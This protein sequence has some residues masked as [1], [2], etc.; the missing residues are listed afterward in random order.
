MGSVVLGMT[1]SLDGF[2]NDRHGDVGR[3]YSDLDDFM[4][5]EAGQEAIA[6][7]GAV[8][9]GRRAY[10]MGQGDFTGYEFQVPI[11]VVTHRAPETA[12][13]GEND[14]LTFTF[15]TDGVERA[16]TQA[17][18][19]AGDR[20][21]VVVGGADV[22]RQCLKAGL[23][24]QLHIDIMPIILGDGLRLFDDRGSPEIRLERTA[25]SAGGARTSF[26]FRV[27]R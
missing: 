7:T 8:V 24:D 4:T 6:T 10:D 18:A 21:V 25:V 23:V 20:N 17:K 14:A 5:T 26:R 15:V 11:F 9:M 27:L 2:V 1:V 22:A 19:A 12:A 13:K 3:L 16:V